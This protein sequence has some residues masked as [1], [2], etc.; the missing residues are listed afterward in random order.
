MSMPLRAMALGVLLVTQAWA[1]PLLELAPQPVP[2]KARCPVCGM[3]PARYPQWK[4]QAVFTD[5]SA[6][7]FDS[8]VEMF[9]FLG[10]MPRYDARHTYADI[11][12]LFVTDFAT[13]A[14]VPAKQAFYVHGAKVSGPMGDANLPAFATR[15]AAQDFAVRQGGRVLTYG[16][17]RPAWVVE[18]WGG[19]QRDGEG[20]HAH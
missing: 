2:E 14:W 8:P 20:G 15:A 17:I 16:E 18:Q 6:A 3:Y 5:R 11:Q 1:A 19:E 7:H 9:L 12:A 10:Q 13:K 4:A